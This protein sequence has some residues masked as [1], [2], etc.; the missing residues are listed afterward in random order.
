MFYLGKKYFKKKYF[1][2]SLK[3]LD[4]NRYL[5]VIKQKFEISILMSNSNKYHLM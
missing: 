1:I 5:L 4:K 2:I 3:W